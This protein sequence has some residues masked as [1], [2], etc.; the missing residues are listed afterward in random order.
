[1]LSNWGDE[2]TRRRM[3]VVPVL[4]FL[5]YMICFV[6]L[7]EYVRPRYWIAS[8]LDA[9][10]PFCSAFLI[11]YL[12]W[13]L[14]VPGMCWYFYKRDPEQYLYLCRMIVVGLTICLTIYA[15]LPNG[16]LL[17]RP[18]VG[19]D[20]LSRLVILLRKTDTPTNVCPSIHVFMTVTIALAGA[21][22]QALNGQIRRQAALMVLSVLIC[23]STVFL[24][25]H[26]VVDV[27]CG[28]ALSLALDVIIRRTDLCMGLFQADLVGRKRKKTVL[29]S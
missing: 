7:E 21:R 14:L 8:D 27:A 10:I 16:Q 1:M 9:Y 28:T 15:I 18:I 4:Y 6:L 24:K 22:S 11:P 5:F 2:R 3:L 29:G 20:I 17:R 13:F 19:D 23:L 25:Q 26:S 12:A